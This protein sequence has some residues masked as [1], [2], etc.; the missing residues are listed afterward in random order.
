MTIASSAEWHAH[1]TTRFHAHPTTRFL[2]D[3]QP[4]AHPTT[5]FL[6]DTQPPAHPTT[7]FLPGPW[8]ADSSAINLNSKQSILLAPAVSTWRLLSP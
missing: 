4:P 1:P 8:D 3:T 7:R 5:R 6:G 2:G